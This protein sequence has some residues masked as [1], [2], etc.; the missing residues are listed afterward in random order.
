[1]VMGEFAVL[2]IPLCHALPLIGT[3][4]TWQEV[5]FF[6]EANKQMAKLVRVGHMM[7]AT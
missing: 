1:M 5:E 3:S 6:H 7:L 2:L 4:E